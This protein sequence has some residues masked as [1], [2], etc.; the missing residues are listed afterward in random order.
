[1]DYSQKCITLSKI[2]VGGHFDDETEE[3]QGD[4]FDFY[5]LYGFMCGSTFIYYHDSQRDCVRKRY[6]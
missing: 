3:E 5:L 6:E 2:I 1:M 4:I